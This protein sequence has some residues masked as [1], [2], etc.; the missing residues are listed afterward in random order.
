VALH[1]I[2]EHFDC[3][4]GELGHPMLVEG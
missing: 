1:E 4:P 3:R 2:G